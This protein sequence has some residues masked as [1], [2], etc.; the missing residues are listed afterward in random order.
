M[1]NLLKLFF[2]ITVIVTNY[3]FAGEDNSTPK[4]GLYQCGLSFTEYVDIS[5]A[6]GEDF[7]TFGGNLDIP[8][9]RDEVLLVQFSGNDV[10]VVNP[11]ALP[12][13]LLITKPFFDKQSSF[14]WD[15]ELGS[16]TFQIDWHGTW[17]FGST[18]RLSPSQIK[19]KSF[20]AIVHFDDND[21]WSQTLESVGCQKI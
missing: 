18:L 13:W 4:S 15:N 3:A 6:P 7:P 10:E 17:Y 8:K 21:G 16:R 2:V 1:M 20:S 5:I 11:Q 19:E 9:K 14:F 12:N